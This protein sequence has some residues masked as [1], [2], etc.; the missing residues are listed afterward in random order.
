M[1]SRIVGLILLLAASSY[2]P[3]TY[4]WSGFVHEL[5]CEMALL[6]LSDEH[7]RVVQRLSIG[8]NAAR[9]YAGFAKSCVWADEVRS[10]DRLETSP[11]HY[12]NVPKD[13]EILDFSRVCAAYDCVNQAIVR[14]LLYF[15][16]TNKENKA[17]AVALRFVGHFVGDLHQ[18]LHNGFPDDL[19][20]NLIFVKLSPDDPLQYNLHAIWDGRIAF[21]AGLRI[22]KKRDRKAFRALAQK[23][24]ALITEEQKQNWRHEHVKRWV[25]AA[26]DVARNCAYRIDCDKDS[27]FIANNAVLTETYWDRVTPIALERIRMSSVRLA[28]LLELALNQTIDIDRLEL[29]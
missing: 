8:E 7:R 22:K 11:M 17:R 19:G 9:D 4:A 5:I 24:V 18:P 6:Q 1:K 27:A 20:G 16:D 2:T 10:T 25:T 13:M 28:Y 26:H 15:A 29:E 23:Q 3:T 12:L 14:Y 21:R